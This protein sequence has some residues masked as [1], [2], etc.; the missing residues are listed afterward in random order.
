MVFYGG[1]G[2]DT[3]LYL[4]S[5][6]PFDTLIKVFFVPLYLQNVLGQTPIISAAL[7]LPLVLSQVITTSISGYVV[8]YTNRTWASFTTGFIVWLA[9]QGA[10]LCFEVD[11]PI[12]VIIGVLLLQ[13][14]GI[15]S[16]IQSSGSASADCTDVVALV[17]A[18][19]SGPDG[20][21]AAVTGVRK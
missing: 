21:R 6:S 19:A 18:Q 5:S 7:L 12:G 11:T 16:T 15:G 1:S 2:C 13:G 4:A 17:L 8:K 10:Q 9:G 20:D 3:V 14:L